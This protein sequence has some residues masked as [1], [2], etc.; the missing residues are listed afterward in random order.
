MVQTEPLRVFIA[1][2]VV[3]DI[4]QPELSRLAAVLEPL[5][6]IM[7]VES[8]ADPLASMRSHPHFCKQVVTLIVKLRANAPVVFVVLP[9]HEHWGLVW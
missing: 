4:D 9:I 1:Q 3:G 6:G 7:L 2:E 8:Q 5:P